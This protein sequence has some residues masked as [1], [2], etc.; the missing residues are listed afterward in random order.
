M[1]L[2][3][4]EL[5]MDAE[6]EFGITIDGADD[7]GQSVATVGGFYDLVVRLVRAKGKPEARRD[8]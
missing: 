3:Q 6:D 7:H 4:I 5:V 2:E 8:A 1:G